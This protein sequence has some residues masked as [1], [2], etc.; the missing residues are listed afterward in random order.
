M[1]LGTEILAGCG[2]MGNPDGGQFA[3]RAR[4]LDAGQILAQLLGEIVP[5]EQLNE[6]ATPEFSFAV[7]QRALQKV[8]EM[9]HD[10]V[11]WRDW[12]RQRGEGFRSPPAITW[13]GGREGS[14]FRHLPWCGSSQLAVRED[15]K[16]LQDH[17]PLREFLHLSDIQDVLMRALYFRSFGLEQL[18][19][20]TLSTPQRSSHEVLVRVKA[21]GITAS[22]VKNVQGKMPHTTLPRI[23]GRDFAGLVE[24]GPADFVGQEVWGTGGEL[25]FTRDGSHGE[26][27]VVP[28]SAITAKP[29]GLTLEEAACAGVSLVTAWAALFDRAQVRRGEN[30]LVVGAAG[31]VGRVAVELAR[32]ADARVTGIVRNATERS[33]ADQVIASR[34]PDFPEQLSRALPEGADIV[35]DTVGGEMFRH[36]F[37]ALRKHGRMVVIAS[38]DNLETPLN[39]LELYRKDI[40]LHGLN[41][42]SLKA[43][44]CAGILQG[45]ARLYQGGWL[46][47][48]E[49]E[50]HSL[51]N[52]SEAYRRAAKGGKKQLLVMD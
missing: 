45:V 51:D 13:P 8:V 19:L 46:S 20:A 42:L 4:V 39:L 5:G 22:D 34:S 21:A 27:V 31:Q 6:F 35:F 37:G 26:Y 29:S 17:L 16:F 36:G 25:G 9:V 50:A 23:P 12:A 38:G 32:W 24:D 1:N 3:F 40:T 48:P 49:Y 47:R 41:T 52:W 11:L 15:N 28:S 2:S 44:E 18:C 7:A 14:D 10:D 30:V 43:D 33:R